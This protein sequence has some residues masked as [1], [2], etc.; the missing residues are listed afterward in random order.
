MIDKMNNY[1]IHHQKVDIYY[2]EKIFMEKNL[3]VN[4]SV[5]NIT[6]NI[7]MKNHNI[8]GIQEY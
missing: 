3:I 6:S 5:I 7:T 2:I 1:E 8:L 4:Q